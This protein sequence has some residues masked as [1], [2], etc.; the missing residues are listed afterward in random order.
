M[1]KYNIL[2][3]RWDSICEDGISHGL[4]Q[5]GQNVDDFTH[6]FQSLDYDTDYLKRLSNRLLEKRYDGVFSVNFIPIISRVCDVMKIPY[7]CWIVDSPCFQLFSNTIRNPWNR[8]FMFDRSQYEKFYAE[9]PDHIFHMP[10]ACDY[11][12]WNACMVTKEDRRLYTADISFIGSTYEEKCF[13]NKIENLPDDLRGY[14]EGVIQSQLNVYGYNFIEDALTEEFCSRFKES[15][16]WNPLGEDYTEDVK[17]IIADTFIGE[18]C[19]EQERLLTL[20]KISEHADLDLYTLS[21]VSKLPKANNRGGADSVLMMPKI[22]KCS[23]I[24]LNITSRPIKTGIPLRI[25]DILGAGGFVLT[26]YQAE[27]LDHFE[28]GKD[29]AVYESQIDLLDQISY[30]LKHEDVRI[31]IAENG[32]KK[33]KE[34]HSYKVRLARILDLAFKGTGS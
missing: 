11:E 32:K 1:E 2:F 19:T 13:Y 3:C 29:L 14:V 10:L 12:T 5:L 7:I 15:V 16:Q 9:N 18:K 6:K 31:E 20:K 30:Y 23:K 33:V 24:N 34:Q 27:I 4:Q 17:A 21:D 25:F 28:I 22:F 26:N 8:I